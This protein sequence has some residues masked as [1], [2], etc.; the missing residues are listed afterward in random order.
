MDSWAPDENPVL[1]RHIHTR[2]RRGGAFTAIALVALACI[3][4]VVVGELIASKNGSSARETAKVLFFVLLAVPGLLLILGGTNRVNLTISL[5]RNSGILE[6]LRLTPL[7]PGVTLTG[8]VAGAPLQEI[9]ASLVALPFLFYC[10]VRG[11]VAFIDAIQWGV[12]LGTTALLFYLFASVNAL[13]GAPG[14]TQSRAGSAILLFFLIF[15]LPNLI[16]ALSFSRGGGTDWNTFTFFGIPL[17]FI[18]HALLWKGL[19]IVFLALAAMRKLAREGA[20]AL[21]KRQAV[22]FFALLHLLILGSAWSWLRETARGTAGTGAPFAPFLT[23]TIGVA[24]AGGI[25]GLWLAATMVPQPPAFRREEERARARGGRPRPASEGASQTRWVLVLGAIAAIFLLAPVPVLLAQQTPLAQ[26]P[27][28]IL[29]P[30]AIAALALLGFGTSRECC[31][32]LARRHGGGVHLV[33][34][35]AA[36]GAPLIL[37]AVVGMGSE[38]AG[39]LVAGISP[40]AGFAAAIG[41]LDPA[42]SIVGPE[43][44]LASLVSIVALSAFA[45]FFLVKLRAV[46]GRIRGRLPARPPAASA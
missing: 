46:H 38:T 5:E 32:L 45:A 13:S 9:A 3:A 28:A 36:W 39:G 2:L 30:P 41:A 7:H 27:P 35:A 16:A 17:P 8:Y 1:I 22:L 42:D 43:P 34:I 25:V 26:L 11:G 18:F 29:I 23:W 33:L 24:I 10:I 21:A 15:G 14:R 37:G 4:I 19:F 44:L 6:S 12:A 40:L 20:P 31:I